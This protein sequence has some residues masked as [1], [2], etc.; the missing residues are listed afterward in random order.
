VGKAAGWECAGGVRSVF[1]VKDP[2]PAQAFAEGR[3]SLSGI[4][5]N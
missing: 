4:I 3:T 2:E 1:G 5:A